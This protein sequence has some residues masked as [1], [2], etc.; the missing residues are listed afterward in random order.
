MTNRKHRRI[1]R[2][3][4][5]GRLWSLISLFHPSQERIAWLEILEN[6]I[7]AIS[8]KTTRKEY[9]EI[10]QKMIISLDDPSTRLWETDHEVSYKKLS[11]SK[12]VEFIRGNEIVV[13]NPCKISQSA[14][15]E[16]AAIGLVD[17][18]VDDVRKADAVV[19]DLRSSANCMPGI[20]IDKVVDQSKLPSVLCHETLVSPTEASRFYSGLKPSVGTTTGGYYNKWSK[21]GGKTF[22]PENGSKH[23]QIVFIV[24]RFSK[25]P[26]V[27]LAL[28]FNGACSVVADGPIS[29]TVGN[30]AT[31]IRIAEVGTI[32]IRLGEFIYNGTARGGFV[33]NTVTEHCEI[34]D[35]ALQNAIAIVKHRKLKVGK[36]KPLVPVRIKPPPMRK[37]YPSR[38]QRIYAAIRIWMVFTYFY[39]YNRIIDTNWNDVLLESLPLFEECKN[40]KEYALA[41]SNMTSKAYDSHVHVSSAALKNFFGTASPPFVSRMIEGRPVVTYLDPESSHTNTLKVGDILLSIDGTNIAEKM[42]EVSRYFSAST[43]QSKEQKVLN[44]ILLGREGSAIS[45]V[46]KDSENTKNLQLTRSNRHQYLHMH[47]TSTLKDITILQNNIGYVDLTKLPKSKVGE[48]FEILKNTISIIFDMR[49]YPLGTAWDISARLS[50]HNKTR[51]GLRKIRHPYVPAAL[52]RCPILS[53]SDNSDQIQPQQTETSFMQCVPWSDQWK[54]D[55]PTVMLIDE[56]TVSQAEHTGLFFK[57]ANN[58]TFI[59]SRTVGAN[60]DITNFTIPGRIKITLSGQSVEHP[61]ERQLQRVGLIPDIEIKPTIEGIRQGTDEVLDKAIKYLSC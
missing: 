34:E 22:S 46:V 49:G 31:S 19:I 35:L 16:N 51:V 21:H 58:T 43:R 17:N 30:K 29:A 37:A 25:L 2:I 28:Q 24:N 26:K 47:K 9:A 1:E 52:F 12:S 59:G 56:R 32:D 11:N 60:G 39:P 57:A 10:V 45:L 41:V 33:P 4:D 40:A 53:V 20:S 42:N 27:A 23:K 38:F 61:D 6:T 3:S 8:T 54:Y 15:N 44:C 5:V 36:Y 48:M 13:I 7:C 14:K 55:K 50:K 18:I